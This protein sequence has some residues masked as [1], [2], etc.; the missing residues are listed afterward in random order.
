M[1]KINTSTDALV[2]MTLME[3][4]KAPSTVCEGRELRSDMGGVTVRPIDDEFPSIWN[5]GMRLQPHQVK[6]TIYSAQPIFS[7]TLQAG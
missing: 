4:R 3:V 7:S 2:D 5:V 6:N 1:G